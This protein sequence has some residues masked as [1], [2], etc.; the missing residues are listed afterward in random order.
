MILP[1]KCNVVTGNPI[2]ESRQQEQPTY[3][4]SEDWTRLIQKE[5]ATL[6][7]PCEVVLPPSPAQIHSKSNIYVQ[8]NHR[9]V[10]MVWTSSSVPGEISSTVTQIE[11]QRL[12][13][14]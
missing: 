14:T 1:K 10:Y 9:I 12:S 4:I 7:K 5:N 11:R 2:I 8:Q 13:P 3:D 6:A